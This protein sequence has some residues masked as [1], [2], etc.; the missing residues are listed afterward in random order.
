MAHADVATCS[1]ETDSTTMTSLSVPTWIGYLA[2]IFVV[3]ALA[4]V[5]TIAFTA[6]GTG[7]LNSYLDARRRHSPSRRLWFAAMWLCYALSGVAIAA[8]LFVFVT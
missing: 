6:A 2:A 4:A 1:T 3:I 8:G 5:I 7:A